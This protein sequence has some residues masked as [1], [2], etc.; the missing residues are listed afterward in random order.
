MIMLI[1]LWAL[2]SDRF[3][4]CLNRRQHG[5]ILFVWWRRRKNEM[6]QRKASFRHRRKKKCNNSSLSHCHSDFT[7]WLHSPSMS[8]C[9]RVPLDDDDPI[10][11][12]REEMMELSDVL[13]EKAEDVV[14]DTI[15][16]LDA[17]K[18]NHDTLIDYQKQISIAKSPCTSHTYTD[19]TSLI[20]S[21]CSL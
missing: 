16:L 4:V 7:V 1:Q 9:R 21:C 15:V 10:T 11:R 14:K 6:Y 2:Y 3:H 20:H 5:V 18:L 8:L 12:T 13:E 17:L 19:F